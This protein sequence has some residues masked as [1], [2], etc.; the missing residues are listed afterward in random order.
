MKNLRQI[1]RENL[2]QIVKEQGSLP[3][4]FDKYTYYKDIAYRLY[5]AMEGGGT[6]PEEVVDA[7]KRINNPEDYYEVESLFKTYN[8]Y[9]SISDAI[10]KEFRIRGTTGLMDDYQEFLQIKNHLESKGI[11]VSGGWEGGQEKPVIITVPPPKTVPKTDDKKQQ[12]QKKDNT[13]TG[14]SK[15]QV[16]PQDTTT[17]DLQTL[18]SKTPHASE[19]ITSKS[20]TGIDGRWGKKTSTAL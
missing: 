4:A 8:L 9:P 10:S 12:P 6:D 2:K 17:R 3:P 20:K 14:G 13:K 19:I 11:K 1:I 18:I 7:I 16:T 5:D 15:P